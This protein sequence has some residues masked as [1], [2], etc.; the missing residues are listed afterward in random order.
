[1]ENSGQDNKPPEATQCAAQAAECQTNDHPQF[2]HALQSAYKQRAKSVVMLSG[3]THDLY[4]CAQKRAFLPLDQTLYYAFKE[5]VTVVRVDAAT[6]LDTFDSLDLSDL[7]LACKEADKVTTEE[8]EKMG[9][10][11]T[12]IE[13][14]RQSPLTALVVLRDML[15]SV[16]KA[17]RTMKQLEKDQA[18]KP[19][20][21]KKPAP[22]KVKPVCTI[23]QFAGSLFP[24]GNFDHLS[25]I[26]RQRLIT[27]LNLIE[28]PK[29]KQSF[30]LIILVADTKSE[31]NS[32]I[33]ALP[34]VQAIEIGL[35]EKADRRKYVDTFSS[36]RTGDSASGLSFEKGVD[37]FVDDTAGLTLIALQ[38]ILEVGCNSKQQIM[39]KDVLA[40]IN[41]VMSAS[42]GDIIKVSMPEHTS[43]DVVGHEQTGKIFK[44]IF[45]RCEDPKRAVP[46]VLVSGPNGAGKTFQLEAYAAE[47][48][49][50]VIELT[51]L[52]SMYFGQTDV[53][54]EKL[55]MCMKSYNK[56]MVL[57]DEAHTALASVSSKETH[58][59]E[60]RLMGNLIKL[61]G[62][63][64]FYGQWVWSFGTSRPDLLP[65]DI[66]SRAPVQIPI[67]DLTGD[68]RKTFVIQLFERKGI[69]I[70]AED[71]DA[72]LA[73][74]ESYSSRDY[75]FLVR[76]VMGS[77]RTV[78]ETL[79]VWQAS[80]SIVEERRLQSLI[81]SQHCS[82]PSLVP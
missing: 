52:R 20:S 57:M 37:G 43:R 68:E 71:I 69:A 17:R 55:Y 63:P 2:L 76:E 8:K 82:Y 36:S 22:P 13:A 80:T 58:E 15:E 38:D 10:L 34:S 1:M 27:F 23:V 66:K 18:A 59:T 64:R 24:N 41:Y 33:V 75:G 4:W 14:T 31:V 65:P 78:L 81:A 9:D 35:P 25:E 39:R 72:V 51:G 45:E 73:G 47:S 53:I 21:P 50:V 26:D 19:D 12:Q 61:I 67:F 11:E 29:F 62:D 3:N 16:D 30:H 42:L 44:E 77:N 48:G 49:R 74:T 46:A 28:S 70:A 56:G 79:S 54:F 7:T 40:S 5:S 6:G 60:K 32:R